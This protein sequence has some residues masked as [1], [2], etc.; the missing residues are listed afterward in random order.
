MPYYKNLSPS[1]LGVSGRLSELIELTLTYGFK[2]LDIDSALLLRKADGRAELAFQ[3]LQ[4]AKVKPG[5]FD[6]PV[7][8]MADD[9]TFASDMQRLARVAEA[10]A[11][12]SAVRTTTYLPAGG[13][14]KPYHELFEFHRKRLAEVADLLNKHGLKLG[15]AFHAPAQYREGAPYPYISTPNALVTMAKA[16]N[17]PNVGIVLDPWQWLVAG[18]SAE[19]M[20]KVPGTQ[21]VSV[22]VAEP[23][24]GADLAAV[25]EKQ[26]RLPVPNGPAQIGELLKHLNATGYEG[27]VTPAPNSSQMAGM[28]RENIVKSASKSVDE[29]LPEV[30]VEANGEPVGAGA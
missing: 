23:P 29:P 2:G 16:I 15:L 6:L 22:R 17:L 28:T 25:D 1:S 7:R 3:L 11:S 27:P 18:A 10:A 30:P 21:I 8:W 26:R 13:G 20:R 24:E 5:E 12:V 14:D 9:P 19:D 4:S